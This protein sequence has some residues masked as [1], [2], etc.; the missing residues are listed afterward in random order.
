MFYLAGCKVIIAA[1][2][3]DELER[4]KDDLILSYSTTVTHTPVVLPLDLTDLN[5]LPNKIKYVLDTLGKID[6]LVNNG[7]L[8]NLHKSASQ[9]VA[10]M[11][12]FTHRW[13]KRTQ[14]CC[15]HES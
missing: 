1:R 4:V 7:T 12:I 11:I 6:I 15:Q 8:T 9:H 14:R 2:R 10:R 13:H 3:K 5:E